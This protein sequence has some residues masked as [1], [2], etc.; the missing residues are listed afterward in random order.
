MEFEIMKGE[1]GSNFCILVRFVEKEDIG[2]VQLW[3]LEDIHVY[4]AR[5]VVIVF[6]ICFLSVCYDVGV[7]DC[8]LIFI[9]NDGRNFKRFFVICIR[10]KKLILIGKIKGC[11]FSV[12]IGEYIGVSSSGS[13][14]YKFTFF[15]IW[16]E[17]NPFVLF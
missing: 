9:L 13:N 8:L 17:I 6:K 1:L 15:K 5:L 2:P 7:F 11:S 3:L 4:W 10:W 16:I 12:N 14:L